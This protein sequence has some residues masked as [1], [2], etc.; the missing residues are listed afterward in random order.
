MD[1]HFTGNPCPVNWNYE[2]L[3]TLVWLESSPRAPAFLS[4]WEAAVA[5]A[6]ALC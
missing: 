4:R 2:S 1:F 3:L 5:A 6:E